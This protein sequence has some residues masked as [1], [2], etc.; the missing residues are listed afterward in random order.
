MKIKTSSIK[1]IFKDMRA[2]SVLESWKDQIGTQI[3]QTQRM[4]EARSAENATER[5]GWEGGLRNQTSEFKPQLHHPPI[6]LLTSN[7]LD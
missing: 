3:V 1:I 7:I 2:K 4:I 6:S 5:Y